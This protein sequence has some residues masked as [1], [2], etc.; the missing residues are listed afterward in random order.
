MYVGH[1]ERRAADNAAVNRP[2]ER[3]RSRRGWRWACA[4]V[5]SLTVAAACGSSNPSASDGTA[6]PA[7][8]RS[9]PLNT[10]TDDTTAGTSRAQ[11]STSVPSG[12]QTTAAEPV[13]RRDGAGSCGSVE[14]TQPS[15]PTIDL[16][17]HNVDGVSV[18]LGVYPRPDYEGGPWTAWGQG[19][20]LDDGRYIS[21]IGDHLGIDGNSFVYVFDPSTSQLTRIGDVLSAVGHQQ[22]SAGHGK[23]HAQMVQINC[24]EVIFATY[25]GR[26]DDLTFTGSYTGGHVMTLDTSSYAIETLG[27]PAPGYAIPSMAAH[28]GLIYGEAADPTLE[29]GTNK[30]V[31]FVF[32]PETRETIYTVGD[33]N[34]E[35]FRSILVD[36]AGTAFVAGGGNRLLAYT[37]GGSLT[38]ASTTLPTGFLRAATEVTADG[39]VYG[40]TD[41]PEEFF[42]IDSGGNVSYLGLAGGYTTSV[43]LTDDNRIVYVPRA[44]GR[45]WKHG[46]SVYLFDPT[47]GTEEV[48]VALNA[49]TERELGLTLGGTYSIAISDDGS[50]L[51]ITFNA[52]R[53]SD[54]PWGEVVLAVI[55][56]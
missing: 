2:K 35:G 39:T 41:E 32:D 15:G 11:T 30:G 49:L 19:I 17:D 47:S 37:P 7:A 9:S 4:V 33:P 27:V 53:S 5:V 48:L 38:S 21:G 20:V 1:V 46:G 3:Q 31:F 42:S 51:F 13:S 23:I 50:T 36:Q 8:S 16:V 10:S 44:H 34:H 55:E 18:K 45:A 22:G 25:W 24:D 40:V 56:L 14:A 12:E 43:A 54:D 28:D 52:G 29:L 26:R 6:E